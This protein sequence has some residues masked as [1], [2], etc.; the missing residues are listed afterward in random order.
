[1]GTSSKRSYCQGTRSL[2]LQHSGRVSPVAPQCMLGTPG[3]P[4]VDALEAQIR[5]FGAEGA[6]DSPSNLETTR[7][8]LFGGIHDNVVI[9]GIVN[10]SAQLLLRFIPEASQASIDLSRPAEHCFPT[11]SFGGKCDDAGPSRTCSRSSYP[12]VVSVRHVKGSM[13]GPICTFAM[14][15]RH[16]Q[17]RF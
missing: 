11:S 5:Q 15:H 10:T 6:I 2:S 16:L 8:Y 12:T 9:P 17:L 1:M 13:C 4:N 7:I 14:I 3:L